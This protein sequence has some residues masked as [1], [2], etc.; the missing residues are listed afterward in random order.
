MNNFV[1]FLK[2]NYLFFFFFI[3]M[4]SKQTEFMQKRFPVGSGP[5]SKI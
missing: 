2:M 4:K 3:G 5:S 1:I